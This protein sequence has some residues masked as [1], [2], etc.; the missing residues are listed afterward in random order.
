MRSA[1]YLKWFFKS[2]NYFDPMG[3]RWADFSF[4][5][6]SGGLAPL[7]VVS[8]NIRHSSKVDDAIRLIQ[9]NGQL[10]DPDIL[11][12][13]EK[14]PEAVAKLARA[15]K[16][17]YVYYPSFVHPEINKDFGNAILSRWPI[18]Q[19]RKIIL[20][21]LDETQ[22]IR[23]AVEALIEIGQ[24]KVRVYCLHMR[25]FLKPDFRRHQL[26][27]LTHDI[28]DGAVY[29][30]V[31]G[32]FNTITRSGLY[33]VNQTFKDKKFVDATKAIGWTHKQRFLLY[34]VRTKLD[35]IFAK[36]FQIKSAG[37]VADLKPSDHLPIWAVL[38]FA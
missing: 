31:G 15:L 4:P 9:N 1:S 29:C 35:H 36:G 18:R 19:D 24:R 28:P 3:P 14:T 33:A 26:E 10:A 8:Y 20:P 16:M 13:Q 11:L 22:H 37:K 12:A 21:H 27:T 34:P 17:N 30:I 25:V 38:E 5:P 2:K 32:D 23:I 6:P 7:K